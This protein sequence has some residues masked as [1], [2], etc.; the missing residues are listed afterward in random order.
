MT[1]QKTPLSALETLPSF[2]VSEISPAFLREE[3]PRWGISSIEDFLGLVEELPNVI[4]ADPQVLAVL[5]AEILEHL[6]PPENLD[7]LEP[8][9]RLPSFGVAPPEL[10]AAPDD[11]LAWRADEQAAGMHALPELDNLPTSISL[12]DGCGPEPRDQGARQTCTAFATAGVLEY[13]L[14]RSTGQPQDLSEQFLYWSMAQNGLLVNE[15]S[16]LAGVFELVRN[17]GVCQDHFWPYEPDHRPGDITHGNP[18]NRQDSEQDAIRHLF[19]TVRFVENPKDVINLRRLLAAGLPVAVEIPLFESYW[20]SSLYYFGQITLPPDGAGIADHHAIILIGYETS[21]QGPS[22]DV[23][24][25]R[26][27]SSRWG[28]DSPWGAGY[29]TVLSEYLENFLESAWFGTV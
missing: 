9:P 22:Q 20:I 23:F 1:R 8:V 6:V 24:L 11:R 10:R 3:L 14:C 5:R 17:A 2:E 25:V 7:L 15:A 29:G 28:R 4:P 26:N 18:P 27:S 16:H 21:L 19:D 13:L 12:L